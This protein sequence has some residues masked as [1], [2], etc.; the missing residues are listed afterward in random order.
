MMKHNTTKAIFDRARIFDLLEIA[1]RPS[2]YDSILFPIA[3]SFWSCGYNTFIFPLS[4]MSI[5][6]RNVGSL[7]NLPP[8][9]DTISLAILISS[10]APKFN[11]KYN[12]SYSGIQE[13]CNNSG[14]E[15]THEEHVAF[16]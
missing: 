6:L 5:M 1:T 9:G 13:L 15:P 16:L 7:V 14:G 3:L 10:A 4:P 12:D 11:K 8:L 2:L